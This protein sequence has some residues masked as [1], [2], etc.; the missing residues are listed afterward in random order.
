MQPVET[1]RTYMGRY[2]LTHLVARGGMAQ[3]YR[4]VDLQL[5]RPVALKV[6]FPELSV[7]KT[8]VERF[9]REAQA[10]A[11]LSHPNIVPVFDWGED[12]GVYFIVMEYVDGRSLSTVLR[13]PQKMP[14][15]QIAQIGA[16]VAAALAFAHRHGVVH[17][18]VKPGN[19]LITPDGEVKVTDFG[20]ARAMNTEESLTQT[21]AVMGTAAYFSPEQAEG[22]TVDA[23]SDIYSL[24]VVLY[25]MAVGRP[26][27]T[28]DSPVAV[29]SKHVRDQPVLPRVANPACPAALEAVIMKAMAKDPAARYGSAEEMRADLLRFADGR[30]VEAGDPNV[31]SVMGAAAAGAAAT[32]M[33]S[34]ATGRTM[35]VPA[36]G[37]AAADSNRD[38]A[39]RKRRTRNLIWLLVLLLIALG[40]IAYFLFSSLNGNV[41]V[42]DVVGQTTAAATQSL[43]S[44]GLTVGLPS[45]SEASA[46]VAAGHVIS[47]VPKAGTSVS[48]NSTVHL[49]VSAGPNIPTVQVPAVTN[50]QLSAAIQKLTASNPPLTYKVKYA[51][52]NQPNGW[53]LSQDPAAGATIKANVPIT[54]TVSNQTV[55]SVPSVLGQSPTAAGASLAR[56]GLNVG[57]TSQGCPAAYQSGT[58]AAQNPGGGA[59]AQ[60]NSSVNL[61]IS[62]CVMVPGVVGQDANSAQNQISN[63]GLTANTTFDTSC[64]NNAQPGNVDSQNPSGGSQVASGGT[65]NISVCQSNTTTTGSSTT[66]TSTSTQGLGVTTT[67]KPGLIRNNNSR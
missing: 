49:I 58:V 29:A 66:T 31:T 46:T 56:A 14:A 57:S 24:G 10:A 40:V 51:P 45:Q 48:K 52:S 67:S 37:I 4:A 59:N 12:D 36:G 2:E 5:D 32:T 25:E 8:F 1:P 60:P 33:M 47:T 21:G 61:V 38:D 19:I 41:T 44:D 26:P 11:N 16:G 64:P 35:A 39:A 34:P 65:V 30:P 27:F 22:K 28:G 54:L 62:N 15:N 18:D 13:D 3:V 23:R 6:L 53:V 17:R 42:P 43:Q 50:E 63:A 7:D 20:I 55:V 9:R